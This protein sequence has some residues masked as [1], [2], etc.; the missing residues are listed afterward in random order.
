MFN[1]E[2]SVL[3]CILL[4]IHYEVIDTSLPMVYTMDIP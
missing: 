4:I 1:L 3:W 2:Y